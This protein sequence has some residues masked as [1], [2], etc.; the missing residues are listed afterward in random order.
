MI[1]VD[2]SYINNYYFD[3]WICTLKNKFNVYEM[4]LYIYKHIIKLNILYNIN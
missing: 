1:K 3:E 2:I 4:E